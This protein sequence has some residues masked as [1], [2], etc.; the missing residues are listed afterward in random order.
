MNRKPGLHLGAL[1]MMAIVLGLALVLR[2]PRLLASLYFNLGS[3]E[4]ARAELALF[5]A[6][7]AQELTLDAVRRQVDLS[8]SEQYYERILALDPSHPQARVQLAQ[9]ALSRGQYGKALEHAAA[10]WQAGHDDWRLRL[11]LGDALVA[12]GRV[13]EGA[14]LVRGLPYAKGRFECWA[15]YRHW[16]NGEYQESANASRALVLLDPENKSAAAA[17]QRAEQKA[18]GN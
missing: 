2:A 10:T 9:I 16:I 1:A 14:E 7:H 15:Y 12:E 11:T 18:R 4:Q 5:D 13:Q 3:A 6:E 8:G 17:V